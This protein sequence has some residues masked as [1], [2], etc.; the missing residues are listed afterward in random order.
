VDTLSHFR[1]RLGAGSDIYFILGLDAFS[2]I[3]TWHDYRRLFE[4]AHFVVT[5]RPTDRSMEPEWSLPPDVGALF[6][7]DPEGF[8]VH[9]SGMRLRY[10]NITA[11]DISATQIRGLVGRGKSIRYLVPPAVDRYI[12]E[13]GLYR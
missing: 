2:E 8:F 9:G 6:S 5:D 13:K 10:H 1:D 7:R 4:L 11:L 12:R 3:A